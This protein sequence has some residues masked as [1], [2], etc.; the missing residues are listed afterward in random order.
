MKKLV[1]AVL[2]G[3]AAVGAY[4]QSNVEEAGL[5]D[6]EKVTLPALTGEQYSK[7]EDN[8]PDP[9]A[10]TSED[11]KDPV[12]VMLVTDS[13]SPNVCLPCQYAENSLSQKLLKPLLETKKE[14]NKYIKIVKVDVSKDNKTTKDAKKRIASRFNLDNRY[15]TILV[16]Y[17]GEIKFRHVGFSL[18]QWAAVK[19][20]I[21]SH[22]NKIFPGTF[23]K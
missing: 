5:K 12:Y 18:S 2:F 17:K 21:Q 9:V 11:E 14:V 15:P 22:I 8:R 6:P 19:K 1:M 7:A 13:G 10:R 3:F 23:L 4:S 16:V 20:N